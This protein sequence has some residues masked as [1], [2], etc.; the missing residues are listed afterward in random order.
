M[1]SYIC[2]TVGLTELRYWSRR[3]IELKPFLGKS[4]YRSVC[5]SGCEGGVKFSFE[6][7][8]GLT[9]RQ[10][11]TGS[12]DCA[13]DL[14]SHK[15][16]GLVCRLLKYRSKITHVVECDLD[17]S[18]R[19]IEIALRRLLILT[20]RG[21]VIEIRIDEIRVGRA[22]LNANRLPAR[23]KILVASVMQPKAV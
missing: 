15:N 6:I 2:D 19:K 11:F 22:Y 1:S 14:R 4:F 16:N 23:V 10:C 17:P 7:E 5:D 3:D 9:E 12:P 13:A 20:D 21:N 18:R 8:V